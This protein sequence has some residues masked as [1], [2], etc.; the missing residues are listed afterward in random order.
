MN[1][2]IDL[3][4]TFVGKVRSLGVRVYQFP[5]LLRREIGL[6]SQLVDWKA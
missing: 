1:F 3:L 4:W 5:V 6:L 2:I